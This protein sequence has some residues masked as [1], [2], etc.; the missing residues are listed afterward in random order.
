MSS[1]WAPSLGLRPQPQTKVKLLLLLLFNICSFYKCKLKHNHFIG[2]L[3][4]GAQP[5]FA[6]ETSRRGE[7]EKYIGIVVAHE[8]IHL[9]LPS[10][11]R[12]RLEVNTIHC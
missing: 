6:A 9:F 3:S 1:I 4:P 7:L 2:T 12:D 5:L 10:K 11:G 8:P